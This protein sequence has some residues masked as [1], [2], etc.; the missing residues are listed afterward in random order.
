[1]KKFIVGILIIVC[2]VL[3][4]IFL[5]GCT[6]NFVTRNY[7]GSM[8]INVQPDEKL[9]NLTWKES[10]LWILT[11]KRSVKDTIKK[12]YF[13]NEKSNFGVMEGKITIVEK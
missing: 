5:G 6:D 7:G 10:E 4:S 11:E 3:F 1:M 12:I 13:F 2:V 9:V 8:T